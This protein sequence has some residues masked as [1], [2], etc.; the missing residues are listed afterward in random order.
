MGLDEIHGFSGINEQESLTL[1]QKALVHAPV[2]VGPPQLPR[3]LD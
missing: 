2:P 3:E 1:P